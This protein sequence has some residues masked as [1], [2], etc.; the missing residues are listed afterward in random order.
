VALVT[1]SV[2]GRDMTIVVLAVAASLL[3]G[4]AR[5]T[6]ARVHERTTETVS[7]GPALLADLVRI[8][9]TGG[10]ALP[11]ALTAVGAALGGEDGADLARVATLLLRGAGWSAAWHGV[12]AAST[13]LADTLEPCW[14]RGVPPSGPLAELA[15]RLR[16]ENIRRG[17]TAAAR[18]GVRLVLPLGLCFLPAFLAL[19]VFPVVLAVVEKLF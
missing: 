8:A 19:G 11:E 5:R 13:N 6:P 2:A 7:V 14:R 12:G 17:Q 9:L 10:V 3:A 4:P 1:G 15:T 16:D 18:L